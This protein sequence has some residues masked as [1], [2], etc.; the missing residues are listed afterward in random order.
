L[1]PLKKIQV[2]VVCLADLPRRYERP[3]ITQQPPSREQHRS[4]GTTELFDREA[5]LQ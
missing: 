2:D 5:V 3:V 1:Q 4:N